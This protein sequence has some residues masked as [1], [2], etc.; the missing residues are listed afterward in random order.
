M[1]AEDAPVEP[2]QEP[3]AAPAAA[4]A[5]DQAGGA[6]REKRVRKTVEVFKPEVKEQVEFTIPQVTDHA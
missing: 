4:A 1:E 5:D 6:A 3:E 2:V